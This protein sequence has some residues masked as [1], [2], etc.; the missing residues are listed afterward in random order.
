ML[1]KFSHR[2]TLGYSRMDSGKVCLRFLTRTQVC[3]FLGKSWEMIEQR[4]CRGLLELGGVTEKT[5][6]PIL[7]PGRLTIGALEN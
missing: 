1:C 7:Q 6:T 5:R 4:T 3:R 2:K